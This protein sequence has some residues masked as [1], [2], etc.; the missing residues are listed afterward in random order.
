MREW[1]IIRHFRWLYYRVQVDRWNAMWSR[2]GY[3]P[4]GRDE[5]HLRD[6]R[7]GRR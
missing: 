1:P 7:D 3:F 6:I 4:I 5:I 2:L